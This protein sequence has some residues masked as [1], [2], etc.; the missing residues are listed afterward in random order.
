MTAIR[1]IR[2]D[3]AAVVTD[4]WDDMARSADDGGPLSARGRR[5]RHPHPVRL[6]SFEHDVRVLT[7][8]R[9]P[10]PPRERPGRK[11]LTPTFGLGCERRP[12]ED[13]ERR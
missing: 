6:G 13:V 7:R 1:R 11:C 9:E 10:E 12:R 2:A 8:E 5:N 4:L 3:E